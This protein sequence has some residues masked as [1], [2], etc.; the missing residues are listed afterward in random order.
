MRQLCWLVCLSGLVAPVNDAL[1]AAEGAS[2]KQWTVVGADRM[3]VVVLDGDVPLF[4]LQNILLGPGW[5]HARL[6]RLAEVEGGKT[7]V[8]RQEQVGFFVN[9]WDR[10]PMEG[11]FDLRYELT[12][13]DAKTFR[14][15]YICTPEFDTAFGIP[16]GMDQKS[17]AIGPVLGPTAWFDR[18]S[19]VLSF[20]D[21]TTEEMP[22]PPPRGHKPA[23]A[24]VA[25]RTAAGE[26]TRLVFDPPAVLHLDNDELRC[27][28]RQETEAGQT[29]TQ[30]VTLHLPQAAAFEPAGRMVDT[31]GWYALRADEANDLARPSLLGM[32]DW[33]EKP[34]G[35]HGFLQMKG[36]RFVFEDGTPV[37]F[38]GV[39][40]LKVDQQVN[41][42]YLAR[43]AAMLERLG[44]NLV[45]FHAFGRPNVP[46]K[47]AHMFK[48]QHVDDG[49]RFDPVHM[50]LF[51]YGFARMKEHGVY[52]AWSVVY[53]WYPTAADRHR[54]I[55]W[56]E[57]QTMLRQS[58]PCENSFYAATGVLPDVQ[59]L[60]I[61]FHVE[62]LN[63]VNPHTGRRYADE[64]AL[65]YIELQNEENIFLG[66]RNYEKLL[67][68]APTYRKQLYRRFAE[69]LKA[70]YGRQE[71]LAA[72]WGGALRPGESIEA[73]NL[74]PFPAWYQGKPNQRIADQ[75][76]FL[77]TTQRDYYRRFEAAVRGTGY[78]GCI[79]GS[80]WQAADWVGHL[81]NVLSDRDIGF[82]DRHN[83]NR[84]NIKRP[85][86][87]L[88]SASFQQVAD[89][90]FTFSEWAGG[91]R[92]GETLDVPL[93]AVYGLGLQGW[94]GS[95]QF[96]WDY[97]GA[98]PY[99]HTGVNDTCNDFGAVSQYPA[100]ARL[101][102]RGD[103]EEGAIV[104]ARRISLPALKDTG[105]V[106][107]IE[108]FSL[109]GGANNKSFNAA[110]PSAA[111]AA[112]RVV[113]QYV[114][115]PVDDPVIDRSAPYVSMQSQTIRSTTGQLVWDHSGR[116]FFTVN[117]PGTKA[118][119]GH[120]GERAQVLGE[121]VI[122]PAT[123][124]SVIYLSAPGKDE[125]VAT[126]QSLL[127]TATARMVD[128]DT[129]CD[130]F[131][132][133]PL[134]AA[135]HR[136]GP[137]VLEPVVATIGL[138]GERPCRVFALDH[139]GRKTDPAVEVPVK[140]TADGCRFKLDGARYQT[141]Y[142]LVERQPD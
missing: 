93:V 62:L 136:T 91:A 46:R 23:V 50:P 2:E 18:G 52:M 112:G 116:G 5:K 106:G 101:V 21:G 142:Y 99:K 20:A 54:V 58:F 79:I 111:L 103:V 24:S 59:D 76:Y 110:V 127:I 42:E 49:L 85:G 53:G 10:E 125:T 34:A 115:G 114:D 1:R 33:Q 63:H 113:L 118:V 3:D 90:P 94:D 11:R 64:P 96:A 26:T 45:R 121:V 74:T 72:A 68:D 120:C 119:V 124:F 32:E 130:D 44:V 86:V 84:A 56:E 12:Q 40:V 61:Q 128:R 47:W 80:C 17:I 133:R 87:G 15:R 131:S 19:C 65:A 71:A 8:Y 25:L 109:L 73:A 28:A 57:L 27:F 16:R 122:E 95:M 129:R 83:Y 29:M 137:L 36:D 7:R 37:K 138:K 41:E 78:R 134:V 132:D 69:W 105:Y 13:I 107:F 81:Y 38:W 82:V 66:V 97:P 43:S 92:V 126:A 48:I 104:G 30:D 108:Q 100:L 77:Y 117:T 14:A 6:D 55:N 51:D 70:K 88:L 139:G 35:G 4:A 9:W 75:M 98:L 60:I 67:E 135:P 89:R 22:L 141:P 31:S 102:R 39:N 123:A 140:Q